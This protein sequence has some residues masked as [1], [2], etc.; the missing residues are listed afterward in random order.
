MEDFIGWNKKT[1]KFLDKEELTF[2]E[3]GS[4]SSVLLDVLGG[5]NK[6]VI[7]FWGIR[8]TDTEGNKIYADSSIV[9]FD[10]KEAGHTNKA[11]GYLYF[12]NFCYR[13][14]ILKTDMRSDI[15]DLPMHFQSANTDFKIIGTLQENPE[16]LEELK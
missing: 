4:Y 8:K 5:I 1:K 15:D 2:V 11:I 3:M 9:E 7:L 6:D 10:F 12:E 16:L 14:K 13:I